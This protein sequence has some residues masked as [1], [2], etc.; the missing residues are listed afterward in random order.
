MTPEEIQNYINNALASGLKT[1][2]SE[3]QEYFKAELGPV[4]ER[5]A[6]FE[7]ALTAPSD[8]G[9]PVNPAT[10]QNLTDPDPAS[11]VLMDRIAGLEKAEANRLEELRTMKLDSAL[12][13]A[14][15]KH[16]PLHLETVTELLANRYKAKAVEKNGEWYL[17]GGAKL[18]EEVDSFFKSESGSHFLP[19]PSGQ[20]L[21]SASTN[22]KV[23]VGNKSLKDLTAEEML[24]DWVL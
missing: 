19:N 5:L 18:A 4:N 9:Q 7:E 3:F 24:T 2:L 22:S 17:P 6:Q 11:K 8:P 1:A 15:G 10:S 23:A 12:I 16:N 20:S 21:G 13:S 14:V